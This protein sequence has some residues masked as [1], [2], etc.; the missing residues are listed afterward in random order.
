MIKKQENVFV[1][2]VTV[3]KDAINVYQAITVIQIVK[4]VIVAM[5][6]LPLPFAMQLENVHVYLIS[7]DVL[8][9]NVALDIINIRNVYHVTAIHMALLAFLAIM[10][11]SVSANIISITINAVNVKKGSTTSPFAKVYNFLTP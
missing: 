5:S 8:V 10:K 7:L 4:L 9:I 2:K 3:V 1:N 11:E 6:V